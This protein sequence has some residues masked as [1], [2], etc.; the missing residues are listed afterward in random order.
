MLSSD[1]FQPFSK[2]LTQKVTKKSEE[3]WSFPTFLTDRQGFWLIAF[4]GEFIGTFST[5]LK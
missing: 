3:K 1:L 5:D 4:Q 2:K